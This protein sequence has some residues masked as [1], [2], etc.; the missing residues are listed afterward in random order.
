MGTYAEDLGDIEMFWRCGACRSLNP[1]ITG[2]EGDSLKCSNC[3][4]VRTT[5][6]FEFPTD[7][8]AAPILSGTFAERA[9]EAPLWQC[10]YCRGSVRDSRGE[11][12]TCGA[13]RRRNR[14]AR[15]P[16]TS[17]YAPPPPAPTARESIPPYVAAAP[18]EPS[19]PVRPPTYPPDSPTIGFGRVVLLVLAALLLLGGAAAFSRWAFA[20]S[21]TTVR[22]ES[23]RWTWTSK[24]EVYRVRGGGGWRSEA[25]EGAYGFACADRQDGYENC[26]PYA[27]HSQIVTEPCRCT[28]GDEVDAGCRS[29]PRTRR[30]DAG[31]AEARYNCRLSATPN[32]NGSARLR[33]TCDT[34]NDCQS[35][36]EDYSEPQCRSRRTE[37]TCDTCSHEEHQTCYRSCP[38]MRSWCRYE[39]G[40]WDY[41]EGKSVSGSDPASIAPPPGFPV[42]FSP[43]E[44]RSDSTTFEIRFRD[45]S[46]G[47]QSWTRS[48]SRAEFSRYRIGQRYAAEYTRSGNFRILSPVVTRAPR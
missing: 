36:T 38:R 29:V 42:A 10:P 16:A 27:C 26:K 43:T 1:G 17:P 20:P 35:A 6:P 41:R 25:P 3:G 46:G 13:E 7:L 9:R 31:C 5:E 44:R 14:P 18:S 32:G 23:M 37:R 24:F 33:R 19:E 21:R 12:E 11:C 48:P 28:G 8:G 4:K 47:G 40:R 39:Y 34:R 30:V 2:P 22:V 45:L 15:S